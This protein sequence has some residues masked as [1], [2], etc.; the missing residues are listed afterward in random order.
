MKKHVNILIDANNFYNRTLYTCNFQ[1][2]DA[3]LFN[4]GDA[5]IYMRK[6]ATDLSS[7]LRKFKGEY[8]NVIFCVDSKSWRK[9]E[10]DLQDAEYKGNRV[11]KET[12]NWEVYN[13]VNRVFCD[14]IKSV[15][16][17][18]IKSENSEAD[19]LIRVYVDYYKKLQENT[20]V[21]S[22]DKD[23]NQL[24][25]FNEN[26][27]N[28]QYNQPPMSSNSIVATESFFEW[29]NR[30]G[31]DVSDGMSAEDLLFNLSAATENSFNDDLRTCFEK[32]KLDYKPTNPEFVVFEK[33][34]RGDSSDNISSIKRGIGKKTVESVWDEYFKDSFS[35]DEAL[36]EV[37]QTTIISAFINAKKIDTVETDECLRRLQQNVKLIV[38]DER[39]CPDYV[40]QKMHQIVEAQDLSPV[41]K[42]NIENMKAL[43]EGT[44]WF[45]KNKA[46][47]TAPAHL[48]PF[49]GMDLPEEKS[50]KSL[51]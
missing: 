31:T 11:K 23:L 25:Y 3:K 21:W 49:A 29:L 30:A 42:S 9:L 6:L 17:N 19:D 46:N 20:I 48:N 32:A 38:L 16:V 26:S 13:H 10:A 44:E 37:F 24:I 36:N 7:F 45:D 1:K 40:N 4:D 18:I 35:I 27:F 5:G 39:T 47:S 15:G 50:T 8:K 51:F 34:V 12:I 43:L 22:A 41:Q 14:I 2:K 33:I 28:V